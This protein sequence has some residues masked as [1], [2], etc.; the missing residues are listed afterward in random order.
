MLEQCASP[1][2]EQAAAALAALCRR[3]RPAV[4]AYTRTRAGS[5]HDAEDLTQGFFAFALERGLFLRA[6]PARG[7][8]RSFLFTCLQRYLNGEADRQR[9]VKRGE[10]LLV[11]LDEALDEGRA[12]FALLIGPAHVRRRAEEARFDRHWAG[13]LIDGVLDDV[14]AECHRSQGDGTFRHF[15]PFLPG[16]PGE[17]TE[18]VHAQVATALGLSLSAFRGV[19]HRMREGYKTRLRAAVALTVAGAAGEIEAEM[20]HLAAAWSAGE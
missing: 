20:R 13:T 16:G 8:F 15:F 4:L 14:A 11:P 10:V 3:Y 12:G 19:L 2:P 6:D 9:A 7:R 17:N 1:E 5:K 18:E